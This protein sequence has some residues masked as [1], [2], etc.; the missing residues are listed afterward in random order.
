[1]TQIYTSNT[2]LVKAKAPIVN[3]TEGDSATIVVDINIEWIDP[4]SAQRLLTYKW[5]ESN[6]NGQSWR[7][8]VDGVS[9]HPLSSSNTTPT[10]TV[11]V[12]DD[13][14][15]DLTLS[16][17]NIATT[18]PITSSL[19][20]DNVL[21]NQ[22][23][24]LYR[25]IVLLYNND[26]N[27]IESVGTSEN[28][29]LNIS[30]KK[31]GHLLPNF[32]IPWDPMNPRGI[33]KA[34]N[35]SFDQNTTIEIFK[36]NKDTCGSQWRI[37]ETGYGNVYLSGSITNDLLVNFPTSYGPNSQSY[38]GYMELQFY[39]DGIWTTQESWVSLQGRS[40]HVF[41]KYGPISPI[42]VSL[43]GDK[44]IDRTFVGTSGNPLIIKAVSTLVGDGNTVNIA[45][46]QDV[47]DTINISWNGTNLGYAAA[48]GII[49]QSFQTITVPAS[50]ILPVTVT[51]TGGVDDYLVV[52]GVRVTSSIGVPISYTF[53]SSTRTFTVGVE[54]YYLSGSGYDYL[55]AFSGSRTSSS[56]TPANRTDSTNILAIDQILQSKNITLYGNSSDWTN[57]GLVLTAASRIQIS[58]IGSIG[59]STNNFSGPSGVASGNN[60]LYSGIPQSALVGRIGVSGTPFYVGDSYNGF[61]NAAGA[62]Y[63]SMNDNSRSDN[64]GYFLSTI[65]YTDLDPLGIRVTTINP[66]V[67][68]PITQDPYFNTV[69]LLANS[70][71][72]SVKDLSNNRRSFTSTNVK[73]GS[74]ISKHGGY[75]S[76][77]GSSGYSVA[78]SDSSLG[79]PGDFTI[80]GWFRFE[81]TDI[82]YQGLLSTYRDR[83]CTGW[84]LLLE[85]NN[86]LYFYAT[87]ISNNDSWPLTIT[88][89]Y[90]PNI[91][92]WI[93][94]VV[95]RL[96][97]SVK[98]FANGVEIGSTTSSINITSG[99]KIELGGYPY[100]AGSF[101][102]SL[103]GYI[104]EIRIT[105]E[106]ARYPQGN[107]PIPTKSF[108]KF[109]YSTI[110]Y[111]DLSVSQ[112]NAVPVYDSTNKN[113]LYYTFN[114][115][116]NNYVGPYSKPGQIS[117]VYSYVNKDVVVA[118]P[119]ISVSEG[120]FQA[121]DGSN[122][123]FRKLGAYDLDCCYMGSYRPDDGY[124]ILTKR[125]DGLCV[126]FDSVRWYANNGYSKGQIVAT[127]SIPGSTGHSNDS[128]TWRS[129]GYN[130]GCCNGDG[131]KNYYEL[132]DE[133]SLPTPTP[134]ATVTSTNVTRTPTPTV[135][136]TRTPT[137]TITPS[138]TTSAIPPSFDPLYNDVVLLLNMSGVNNSQNII[139][140]SLLNNTISV[141]GTAAISTAQ[142][143]FG[144]SSLLVPEATSS[145]NAIYTPSSNA[146]SFGSGNFTIEFWLR[147]NNTPQSGARVFQTTENNDASSGVDIYYPTNLNSLV[148][149]VSDAASNNVVLSLGAT[150]TSAW[151]HYALVRQNHV[152]V[153]YRNGVRIAATN[154][155]LNLAASSGNVV[156]GGNATVGA[157]RSVNAYID[158][159]RVTKASRYTG[160]FTPPVFQI[161]GVGLTPTPTKTPTV[162]PTR[163]TPTPTVTSTP[164]VTPTRTIVYM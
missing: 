75:A 7:D 71:A 128:A 77:Y 86:S 19:T 42:S 95:Q 60:I 79:F 40:E 22:N 136:S 72:D 127:P 144:G 103:S 117:L 6:N 2:V 11:S 116:N 56:S 123:Y 121:F 154:R 16:E 25:C 157:N 149:K 91:N 105:N 80:E 21:L 45:G 61:A 92:E 23:N 150:E 111:I 147:Q 139:D 96:G 106:L 126:V 130:N 46:I 48:P 49:S 162:T 97:T 57:T 155:V 13:Q 161:I 138:V 104:D 145:R 84:V 124:Y 135:T 58:T 27:A 156:I 4:S 114:T 115:T 163:V 94:I 140:S 112:K 65:G 132:T 38:P 88:S 53:T 66:E 64:S 10:K 8:I 160:D 18:K 102:K 118:Q 119:A 125:A 90:I 3:F 20:L 54:N 143:R 109:G 9:D 78:N 108:L 164:T 37:I 153:T 158:D 26:I 32:D 41:N 67:Y 85:G 131:T 47:S 146:F 33:I 99:S 93:H 142:S 137:P 44:I 76:Y 70:D 28:I 34:G 62:L 24:Y 30:E 63:L 89:S 74:E 82:G 5:Q 59:W 107:P 148:A 50:F 52:N 51:I 31:T 83:D 151:N 12:L 98:M 152:F 129:T 35:L 122:R 81:R 68:D 14:L 73:L 110:N 134:T 133:V 1:M 15:K 43:N 101:R 87:N 159:I 17:F 36:L 120:Y 69:S 29:F 39:C 55:I 113:I 141:T 100:M